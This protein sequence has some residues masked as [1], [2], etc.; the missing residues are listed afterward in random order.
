M[1]T[2]NK[3]EMLPQRKEA[4]IRWEERI[5]Q[6]IESDSPKLA[7]YCKAALNKAEITIG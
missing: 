3:N 2:Y 5:K 4:L 1:A 6:L 7:V